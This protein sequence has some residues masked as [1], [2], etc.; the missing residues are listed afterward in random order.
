MQE[1]G[2]LDSSCL[3]AFQNNSQGGCFCRLCSCS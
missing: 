2:S 1:E 3:K